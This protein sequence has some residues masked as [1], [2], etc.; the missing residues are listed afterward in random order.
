MC[1]SHIKVPFNANK[2]TSIPFRL[3]ISARFIDFDIWKPSKY[4]K[5]WE[6]TLTAL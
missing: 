3:H 1:I 4:A 5:Y 2:P 6:Q